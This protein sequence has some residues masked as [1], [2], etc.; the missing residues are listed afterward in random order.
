M[1]LTKEQKQS[2]RK[3]GHAVK[4]FIFISS[5]M[6]GFEAKHRK[7]GARLIVRW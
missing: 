4:N 6:E 3:L 7:T 5:S 1:K 2:I